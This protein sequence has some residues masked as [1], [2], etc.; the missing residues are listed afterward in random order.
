MYSVKPSNPSGSCYNPSS[1][2]TLDTDKFYN[3]LVVTHEMSAINN[4]RR[5]IDDMFRPYPVHYILGR[6]SKNT[7]DL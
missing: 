3:V 2:W 1:T 7:A 4:E 6:S 5:H